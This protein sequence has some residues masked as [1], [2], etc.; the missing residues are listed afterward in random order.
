M[1]P[2]LFSSFLPRQ[3]PEFQNEET[4]TIIQARRGCWVLSQ[5]VSVSEIMLSFTL[6]HLPLDVPACA[7]GTT[8]LPITLLMICSMQATL[9]PAHWGGDPRFLH[10]PWPGCHPHPALRGC[11]TSLS[12]S[13]WNPGSPWGCP[14]ASCLGISQ[15][16]LLLLSLRDLQA[17]QALLWEGRASPFPPRVL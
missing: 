5:P 10:A 7:K 9:G 11:R 13:P 3:W 15:I 8:V 12:L 4:L 14:W 2:Q 16:L 17:S 1:L 6:S